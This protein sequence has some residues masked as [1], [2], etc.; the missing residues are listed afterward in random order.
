[1]ASRMVGGPMFRRRRSIAV[2]G[3]PATRHTGVASVPAPPASPGGAGRAPANDPAD[4]RLLDLA[5][6]VRRLKADKA[7][8]EQR[9]ERATAEARK[10]A[11]AQRAAELKTAAAIK[12]H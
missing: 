12:A 9:A 3:E 5:S 11:E 6:K 1:M 10:C 4:P 2:T 7:A 8:A